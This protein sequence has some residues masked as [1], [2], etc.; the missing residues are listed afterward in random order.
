M[1]KISVVIGYGGLGK[2]IAAE[3]AGDHDVMVMDRTQ[4]LNLEQDNIKKSGFQSI[5]C[6]IVSPTSIHEAVRRLYLE[7]DHVDNYIFSVA[8]KL[9]RKKIICLTPE[10]YRN[11][12][13]VN[14]F[15]VFNVCSEIIPKLM[16]QKNGT[17]TAVTTSA[18]EPNIVSGA[19]GG[20]VSAKY[21]LRGLMRQ[22]SQELAPYLIRVNAVAP[23]FVRTPLQEDIPVRI[24]SFL[25]EKNSMHEVV[26]PQDVAKIVSFLI[27]DQAQALTGLS[28]PI[29]FGD[30][31]NL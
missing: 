13:V 15:G 29:T 23:S 8:S 2:A 22:L 20:Y 31:M 24:D 19:M 5:D 14:V 26:A 10:E 6:D 25:K 18:I 21:A 30:V 16:E 1:K 17:I 28:I 11:D 7:Y 4:V 3:L 12:F 9:Q 27:S